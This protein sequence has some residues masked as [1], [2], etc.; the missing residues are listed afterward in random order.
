M[1]ATSA[2]GVARA[3]VVA[4]RT[5]SS[6][7]SLPVLQLCRNHHVLSDR[8]GK[9]RTSGMVGVAKT[10]NRKRKLGAPPAPRNVHPNAVGHGNRSPPPSRPLCFEGGRK[11]NAFISWWWVF[12]H[13]KSAAGADSP[14]RHPPP[15]SPGEHCTI[16]F[17]RE[18][19]FFLLFLPHRNLA[20]KDVA[21][22]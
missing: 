21:R 3:G 10:L 11:Q 7:R 9:S 2:S 22:T 17:W 20:K 4:Q 14:P 6:L 8:L 19:S 12:S 15:L 13:P 5:A 18:V 16:L 1:D